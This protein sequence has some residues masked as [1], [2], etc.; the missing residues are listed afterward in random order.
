[1]NYV[2]ELLARTPLLYGKFMPNDKATECLNDYIKFKSKE[3]KD[4][5]FKL[6]DVE[7]KKLNLPKDDISFLISFESIIFTHELIVN[8]LSLFKENDNYNLLNFIFNP[9][10]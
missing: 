6:I 7:D 3:T 10:M 5:I 2:F 9:R 8:L 4:F 1:M